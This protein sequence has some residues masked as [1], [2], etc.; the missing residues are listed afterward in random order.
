VW[1]HALAP[2]VVERPREA[3]RLST[4]LREVAAEA[5]HLSLVQFEPP[6]LLLIP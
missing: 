1:A 2:E 5:T 3:C 6:T 4:P